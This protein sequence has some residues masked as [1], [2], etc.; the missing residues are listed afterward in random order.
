MRAI[1]D[2][3]EVKRRRTLVSEMTADRGQFRSEWVHDKGW[4]VVPVETGMSFS[5]DDIKNI[6]SGLRG[7]GHSE[8]FAIATEALEPLPICYSL[9]IT[10]G[11]F[12]EFDRE[13]GLFW[14]LITDEQRS[15]ALS[16]NNTYNLFAGPPNLLE[17]MLG[18]SI[19]NARAE[20]LSFATSV[21]TEP[22]EPMVQVA[23]HYAAL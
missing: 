4:K 13:C 14:F 9:E 21:A 3:M 15:W 19:E 22:D 7:F 2:E 10:E 5:K 1:Q 12:Q 23:R 18:K 6:V 17:A 11:D 20:Y 16:C 8:C